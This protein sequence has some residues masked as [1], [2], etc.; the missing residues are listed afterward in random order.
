MSPQALSASFS[1][2]KLLGESRLIKLSRQVLY[3]SPLSKPAQENPSRCFRLRE[4]HV[5]GISNEYSDLNQHQRGGTCV[6]QTAER[7]ANPLSKVELWVPKEFLVNEWIK[8]GGGGRGAA[9]VRLFHGYLIFVFGSCAAPA[10]LRN[11]KKGPG[12]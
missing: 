12:A 8:W 7:T 2:G 1:S 3:A 4:G 11:A 6:A 10:R 5:R 9:G